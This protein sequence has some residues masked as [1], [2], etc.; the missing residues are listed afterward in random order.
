MGVIKSIGLRLGELAPRHD[1]RTAP[2]HPL[3]SILTGRHAVATFCAGAFLAVYL[4]TLTHYY[5]FDAVSYALQI[6]TFA[7]THDP[8]WLF[9]PHHLLFNA[10]GWCVWRLAL[11]AGYRGG[12]LPV[13][14]AEN[15]AFGAL[16]VGLFYLCLR[17]ILTRSRTIALLISTA[18]GVTF[19]YWICATDARV[20]MPSTVLLIAASYALL[21]AMQA[22]SSR[23]AIW[24]GFLAGLAVLFHQSAGL[25][26]LAGITG[27]AIAD[28]AQG[29]TQ[30]ECRARWMTLGCYT[31]SWVATVCLPYLLIGTLSL[32]LN[33]VGA[34]REWAE[35]YAELG[36]WWSFDILLDLRLDIYAFRRAL[37]VEPLGKS[38]TFHIAHTVPD[39]SLVLYFIALAGWLI[40]I[41]LIVTALPLLF[42]TH[43][44]AILIVSIVWLCSY[45]A[46]FLIWSP[47][48]FVFQTPA[49]V[50]SCVIVAI[51]ASHYR[52]RRK[53]KY[54]LIGLTVWIAIVAASNFIE[55]VRPHLNDASNHYY[56]QALDVR[57]HTRVGDIVVAT[58][59]GDDA[60]AEVY[61]PYFADRAV[62]AIHT[63]MERHHENKDLTILALRQQMDLCRAAGHRV[64]AL[65]ELYSSAEARLEL[66]KRHH[67]TAA[68][69]AEFLSGQAKTLAW[70]AARPSGSIVWELNPN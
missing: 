52:F 24:A 31:S 50:A 48:Y 19:G 6:R 13:L 51:A 16:G 56:I 1:P 61:I 23:R 9:H 29:T 68:D 59:M 49:V 37:F 18:L 14:Q 12:P 43:Y 22:P 40:T 44:R 17:R 70:H 42:K 20:N 46:F 35:R 33:S 7:R 4:T 34:Y 2:K 55:S 64:F 36:W 47:G 11:I 27:V 62:F 66:K 3:L 28:Y 32:H 67:I 25:F 38:G 57:Q 54:S 8:K 63:E 21:V 65:G 5:T 10:L 15:A 26:L 30:D 60:D 45:L 41:Y 69:L 53:G 58:G 39:P